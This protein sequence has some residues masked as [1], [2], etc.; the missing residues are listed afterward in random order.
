MTLCKGLFNVLDSYEEQPD[1]V[2]AM[3]DVYSANGGIFVETIV[4]EEP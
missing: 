3:L 1:E 4:S 2:E